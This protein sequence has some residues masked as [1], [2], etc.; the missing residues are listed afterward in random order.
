MN[1]SKQSVKWGGNPHRLPTESLLQPRASFEAWSE[2]VLGKC[3]PWT[4]T[5]EEAPDALMLV[6]GTVR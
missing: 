5:L 2:T 3:K 4:E 1:V 6:Y